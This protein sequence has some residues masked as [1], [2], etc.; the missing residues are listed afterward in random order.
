MF[1]KILWLEKNLWIGMESNLLEWNAT[2]GNVSLGL[3]HRKC[4]GFTEFG[5]L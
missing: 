3:K 2:M 5:Q 1:G 4:N